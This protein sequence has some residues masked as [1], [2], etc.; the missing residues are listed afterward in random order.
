MLTT[1]TDTALNS[2]LHNS[3][4]SIF[5]YFTLCFIHHKLPAVTT[6]TIT[7]PNISLWCESPP[8]PRCNVTQIMILPALV[9]FPN[10]AAQECFCQHWMACV[11]IRRKCWPTLTHTCTHTHTHTHFHTV[12]A[13]D[14][15][16]ANNSPN[17]TFPLCSVA[18]AA[19]NC[20]EVFMCRTNSA[21]EL[22]VLA[23]STQSYRLCT[24]T[25]ARS[26]SNPLL[27]ES[28]VKAAR[29]S[30][31]THLSSETSNSFKTVM[32]KLYI[33]IRQD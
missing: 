24:L 7:V 29:N 28:G 18:M 22:I 9:T 16:L 30:S 32:T 1:W 10:P 31:K 12:T 25:P 6:D 13:K 4:I 8:L 21:K 33:F 20:S 3:S 17:V 14:R 5:L 15:F 19:I 11:V 27:C 26:L 2:I 23:H